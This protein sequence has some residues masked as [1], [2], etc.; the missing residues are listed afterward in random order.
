MGN[1]QGIKLNIELRPVGDDFESDE[2]RYEWQM[3]IR[4]NYLLV[5]DVN[6]NI[7][8]DVQANKEQAVVSTIHWLG[9]G[10]IIAGSFLCNLPAIAPYAD[11]IDFNDVDIY[12]KSKK[13]VLAFMDRNKDMYMSDYNTDSNIAWKTIKD[14]THFNLI[15]GIAYKDPADLISRF[16]IRAC[17]IAYDPATNEIYSVRGSLADCV[18]RRLI[19]NPIPHN[20][21]I[22]RLLKY[23]KKGFDIDPY[24]RIF[25]SELIKSKSYDP[26]IEIST[27]YRAV[28]VEQI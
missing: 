7:T 20:T 11:P 8:V 28:T 14:G 10:E 17:S 5:G 2:K 18:M 16:D 4:A 26:E 21:T 3:D 24:Q 25:L 22:A 15:F 19:Y 23:T 6:A 13:D 1:G 9:R 27:G 12:F